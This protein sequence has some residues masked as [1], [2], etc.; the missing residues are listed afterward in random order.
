MTKGVGLFFNG[1]S[2]ECGDCGEIKAV[3]EFHPTSQNATWKKKHEGSLPAPAYRSHCKSC[4]SAST[5]RRQLEKL[6]IAYPG[7]FWECDD[8][9][10][11]VR[12]DLKTCNKCGTP[13]KPL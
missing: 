3:Q 11:I 8:C 7:S 2:K 13:R 6:L 10:H 1:S 9:D 4:R 5:Y 12:I